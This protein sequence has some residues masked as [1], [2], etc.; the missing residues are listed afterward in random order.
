MTLATLF[1]VTSRLTGYKR[2]GGKLNGDDNPICIFIGCGVKRKLDFA[3]VYGQ[4][5]PEGRFFLF[6]SHAFSHYSRRRAVDQAFW[7]PFSRGFLG[8]DNGYRHNCRPIS[9]SVCSPALSSESE[10][11][12]TKNEN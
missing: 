4:R 9:L 7:S 5:Q 10:R 11:I 2:S 3:A 6:L 8:A 12:A 1:S